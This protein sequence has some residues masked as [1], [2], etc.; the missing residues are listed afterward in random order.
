MAQRVMA[1][2]GTRNPAARSHVFDRASQISGLG[3]PIS[4][5]GR[6]TLR[7]FDNN[8]F[9]NST[10]AG[11]STED[12]VHIIKPLSTTPWEPDCS[13]QP[14]AFMIPYMLTGDYFYLE[15][16]Y[17]WASWGSFGSAGGQS[18]SW[19]RGLNGKGGYISDQPR[20]IAWCS[21]ARAHAAFFAPDGAPEK[22]YFKALLTDFI[23]A[24]EGARNITGTALQSNPMWGWGNT[25]VRDGNG[26]GD[27]G[28]WGV[29]GLFTRPPPTLR[30]A[31]GGTAPIVAGHVNGS[32]RQISLT[33]QNAFEIAVFGHLKELGY[34]TQAL[35]T[36]TAPYLLGQMTTPG[37]DPYL[38]AQYYT[39]TDQ[40]ANNQYFSTW[41]D[42]QNGWTTEAKNG[43]Y[44][45]FKGY[46][47]D[48]VHGYSPIVLAASSFIKQEANGTAAW[49]FL[50]EQILNDPNA[51]TAFN[52]LPKWKILP[53]P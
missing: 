22:V 43:A 26:S 20:G 47:T 33:W 9:L 7:L 40:S 11:T 19:S 35:L 12:Q 23:A 13:H 49:N 10:S 24:S 38:V 45:T 44:Q 50:T 53:R 46:N 41:L 3:R 17:F 1:F 4:V 36:W 2:S 21:R 5:S 34:P 27:K 32:V 28:L 29:Y 52:S 31:D 42:V 37:Y 8:A 51:V 25:I 14:N 18:I 48:P 16:L 6:P 30:F 39:P 15:Q